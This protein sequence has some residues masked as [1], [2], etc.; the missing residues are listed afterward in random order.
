[1]SELYHYQLMAKYNTRM[2]LQVY[3]G[4]LSLDANLCN[5]DFGA[6]FQSITGTLNHI[7]V[8]DILWFTRFS[9]HSVSYT[10]LNKIAHVAQPKLLNEILFDKIEELY[11][12]RKDVDAL[13]ERWVETELAEADLG[14]GLVFKNSKGIRSHKPFRELLSHV[15]NHQTHHRGQVS[16]LLYQNGVDVGITDFLMDIPSCD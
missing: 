12:V 7:L 10:S 9:A 8:G 6:F 11:I 5:K 2:N 13:I 4:A 15:F 16:T 3:D 14:R 1:M